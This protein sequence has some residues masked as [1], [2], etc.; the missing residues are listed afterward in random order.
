VEILST[1]FYF[2]I[3]IGILALVHEFGHF[4]TARLTGMRAEVFA[5]GFGP[6]LFGYNKI[7]KFTFGKLKDEIELGQNTDYRIC[8]FP[9]GGFVKISGMIDESMDKSTV[10]S[11]PQPWEYRSK[12]IW[13]RTIV[14]TAGVLMNFLLGF[15]IF[16]AINI[17]KGKD[18]IDTTTIGYVEKN[19]LSEAAGLKEKDRIISINK[20]TISNWQDINQAFINYYGED[21]NFRINRN[22][23]DTLLFLPSQ[24]FATVSDPMNFGLK[25]DSTLIVIRDVLSGKPA[26]ASGIKPLDLLIKVN[27]ETIKNQNYL[28]ELIRSNAGKFCIF[29]YERDGIR[30][31]TDIKVGEDS[32][33]GIVYGETYLGNIKNIKYGILSAVPETIGDMYRFIALTLESLYK[34]IKGDIPF[35]KA[36]GGP[37]K[38]AQFSAKSA[39]GGFFPFMQF[40]AWL[41]ITLAIFNILPFP[42]LD[43][44]HFIVLMYEAVFRKPIPNKVQITIQYIGMI[45]LLA[46][47]LFVIY[48]DII[49]SIK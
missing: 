44:G 31:T 27:G 46:F 3:I 47:M 30:H 6:R 5:I 23:K 36:V 24:S 43:G 20:E 41:S 10:S 11:A 17:L 26:E 33:I 28:S 35:R 12:P 13:K 8:A 9:I 14:I 18:I 48:N 7:N 40:L 19:S 42:A 4:I 45:F 15:L 34:I 32:L 25:P 21:I 16:Y 2:L 49:T 37:V 39:E 22:G 38:I 29:E 1:I